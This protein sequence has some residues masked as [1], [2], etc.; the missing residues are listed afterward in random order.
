[1]FFS[2]ELEPSNNGYDNNGSHYNFDTFD[3]L[4]VENDQKIYTKVILKNKIK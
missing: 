4:G 1:M 3:N 2:L